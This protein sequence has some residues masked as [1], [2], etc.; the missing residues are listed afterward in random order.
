MIQQTGRRHVEA[1]RDAAGPAVAARLQPLMKRC[2]QRIDDFVIGIA[3]RCQ[4][5]LF[6]DDQIG[7]RPCGECCRRIMTRF[8]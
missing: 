8:I 1:A 2:S 5:R 3:E 7:A 4:Y 6:I